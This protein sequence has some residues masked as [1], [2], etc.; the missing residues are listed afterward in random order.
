MVVASVVAD[1]GADQRGDHDFVRFNASSI[2]FAASATGR[3]N[4]FLDLADFNS[5]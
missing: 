3:F 4:R 1:R 5:S 2:V